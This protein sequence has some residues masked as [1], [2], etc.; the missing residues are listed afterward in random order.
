M[1]SKFVSS[2]F[3]FAICTYLLRLMKSRLNHVETILFQMIITV[4]K[5]LFGWLL[6]FFKTPLRCI[7]RYKDNDYRQIDRAMSKMLALTNRVTIISEILKKLPVSLPP[8]DYITRPQPVSRHHLGLIVNGVCQ[9]RL[10][11]IC[12]LFL[13]HLIHSYFWYPPSVAAR[14]R[15]ISF[16]TFIAYC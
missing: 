4:D 12:K 6:F 2:E 13:F 1:L 8:N 5:L 15:Y 7:S 11:I 9:V 3:H 14:L 10:L 16:F